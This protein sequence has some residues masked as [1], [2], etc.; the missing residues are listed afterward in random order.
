LKRLEENIK[1]ADIDLSAE[2]LSELNNAL[3]NIKIAGS[4]IGR[5]K[6]DY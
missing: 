3:S 4:R 1:A 5:V 6:N 2:E